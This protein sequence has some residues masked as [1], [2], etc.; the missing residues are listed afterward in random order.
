MSARDGMV[1][2]RRGVLSLARGPEPP[3]PGDYRLRST[4]A[5][6]WPSAVKVPTSP[7]ST[8][9]AMAPA[10]AANRGP[11]SQTNDFPTNAA[12]PTNNHGDLPAQ[13]FFRR[14]P[15]NLSLFQSPILNAKRLG[16][17]QRHVIAMHL[18]Q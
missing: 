5:G 6:F 8:V 7:S 16:R 9:A 14:L 11:G 17:R 15:L 2:A 12:A 10:A 13:F 1:A 3:L 18:K 4:D